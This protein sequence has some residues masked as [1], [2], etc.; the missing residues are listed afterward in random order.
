M[1]VNALNEDAQKVISKAFEVLKSKD[2]NNSTTIK[3]ILKQADAY[4]EFGNIDARKLRP[5]DLANIRK[6]TEHKFSWTYDSNAGE[7]ILIKEER[8]KNKKLKP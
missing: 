8:S 7:A 5:E 4:D 3:A 2:N 1:G 6:I